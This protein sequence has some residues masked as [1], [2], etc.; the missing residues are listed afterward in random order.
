M[1]PPP[2]S[3]L[4]P[5]RRSS[6]LRALDRVVLARYLPGQRIDIRHEAVAELVVAHQDGL[7]PVEAPQLVMRPVAM[8]AEDRTERAVLEPA[9]VE[10]LKRGIGERIVVGRPIATDVC[11][12]I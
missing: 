9:H 3:T 1:R 10:L 11:G 5:T 2:R 8:G 6:D 12:P 4:F 7:N